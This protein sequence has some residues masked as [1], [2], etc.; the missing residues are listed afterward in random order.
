MAYRDDELLAVIERDSPGV[1]LAP[2]S[3]VEALEVVPDRAGAM[4]AAL[5]RATTTVETAY[6]V[7]SASIEPTI[8]LS[9]ASGH[10]CYRVIPTADGH[11]LPLGA[12]GAVDPD[13]LAAALRHAA[14]ERGVLPPG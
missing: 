9:G 10:I 1:L 5:R 12:E 2:R 11:P 8:E 6:G 13:L 4:L 14:V 7:S 3:H